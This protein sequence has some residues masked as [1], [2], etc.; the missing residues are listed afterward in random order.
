MTTP[1]KLVTQT[2]AVVKGIEAAFATLSPL[3]GW[4]PDTD[5]FGLK[6]VKLLGLARTYVVKAR[7]LAGQSG[8]ANDKVHEALQEAY[9]VVREAADAYIGVA[10]A[11]THVQVGDQRFDSKSNG[12]VNRLI[13]GVQDFSKVLEQARQLVAKPYDPKHWA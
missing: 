8:V 7:D 13:D 12:H 9:A 1:K 3:Q 5:R 6:A 4:H 2:N 11:A 10:N